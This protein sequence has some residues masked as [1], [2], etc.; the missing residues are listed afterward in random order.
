MHGTSGGGGGGGGGG[1]RARLC[2]KERRLKTFWNFNKIKM[3]FFFVFFPLRARKEEKEGYG[4]SKGHFDVTPL[5]P[6][7]TIDP[8]T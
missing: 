5:H 7:E 6:P 8:T 3:L 4:R 1:G 2:P